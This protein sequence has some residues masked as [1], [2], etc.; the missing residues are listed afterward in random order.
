MIGRGWPLSLP[1]VAKRNGAA[2]V[3]IN[4]DPTELDPH[5]DLVINADIGDTLSA[6]IA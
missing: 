1:V 6:V 4:R 3:I 5:A 2:L